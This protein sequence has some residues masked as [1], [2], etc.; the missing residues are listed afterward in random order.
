MPPHWQALERYGS[1]RIIARNQ[2]K[3]IGEL[4]K[5]M[6][7]RVS[8]NLNT[9]NDPCD[10]IVIGRYSFSATP[11][12]TP[13]DSNTGLPKPNAMKVVARR[14]TNSHGAIPLIFGPIAQVNTANVSR[15]AIAQ[16]QGG[17]GAG[18]L[19]LSEDPEDAPSLNFNGGPEVDVID[20]SIQVNMTNPSDPVG[21]GGSQVL[22]SADEFNAVSKTDS[23]DGYVFDQATGL[24]LTTGQPKIP[25]PYRNVPAP[26]PDPSNPMNGDIPTGGVPVTFEAGYYPD[27]FGK[28]STGDNVTFKPGV[29]WVGHKNPSVGLDIAG[30]HVCAKRVLFYIAPGAA[31]KITGGG[32]DP[33]ITITEINDVEPGIGCDGNAITYSQGIPYVAPYRGMSIFQSR[34]N[35]ND[36]DVGGGN[37]LNIQGTIY[38]PNNHVKLSGGSGSLGIEVVAY[39]LTI[40]G[41]GPGNKKLLISYDGRNRTPAG[42]AY[43][44]E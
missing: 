21:L 22:V 37:G 29:Y 35:F 39:T 27:G 5:A 3:F 20:G 7:D 6:G 11:R 28:I 30:G 12:F 38:F 4:N 2:A 23:T 24:T 14:T 42:R 41:T 1:I 32:S 26:L 43:L 16:A 17:L 33:N 15:F 8:L 34:T 13:T 9:I 36:A 18:L 40:D 10:D 31:V 19:V 44:V 25:D